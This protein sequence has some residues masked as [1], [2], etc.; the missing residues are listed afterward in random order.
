MT[1]ALADIFQACKHLFD[2]F[3]TVVLGYACTLR[4]CKLARANHLKYVHVRDCD[5]FECM[6]R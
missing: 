5:V 3:Y 6:A 1:C 2:Q 4:L